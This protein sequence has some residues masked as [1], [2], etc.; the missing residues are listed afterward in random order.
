M[1]G[2]FEQAKTFFLQGLDHYQAGR[3]VQ[4]ERDFAASLALLPGRAST[5][6]NLGA[7]RI[8][9]GRFADAA[10]LLA[11]AIAQEPDN[12]EAHAQRA[13]ALAELG[14]LE[15]ALASVERAL[16]LDP[17]RGAAWTLRGSLLRTLGR[18]PEAT[19]AFQ[20]AL[21]NG[22]DTE[23]NRYY[24]ASLTGDPPPPAAPRQY[25]RSLFDSY[26]DGFQAHLVEVLHYRAPALLLGEL[27]RSGRHFSAAL[28]L[29]CGTGL[30]G[31]LLRRLASRVDGVDLS[32]NMVQQ[33]GRTQAYDQVLHADLVDYLLD[34]AQRYEL[35]V[36]A[37]VFIYVGALESVFEGVA[38][39]L[40]PK[41]LFCFTV[42]AARGGEELILQSSL[43][44]AHSIG[45]IRKLAEPYG[46]DIAATSEHPIRDDQGTPIPGLFA[47]LARR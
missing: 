2:T 9:L 13:A 27:E 11:E 32:Q 29:G 42:E 26:A 38:R 18:N 7:T 23:L 20:Q 5:L 12:V 15:P 22:A 43:R 41:G 21:A 35:V 30:C 14:Q 39:V 40:E 25:V 6:T 45:Y 34:T 16:Q 28:D 47:W 31:P 3:L 8:K 37:D 17:A 1:P 4:A 44:Y 10:D 33:A 46:F 36:A 24:L 19:A